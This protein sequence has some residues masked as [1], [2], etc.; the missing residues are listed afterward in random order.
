M[1]KPFEVVFI[2]IPA[3]WKNIIIAHFD[4]MMVHKVWESPVQELLKILW[5]GM[6]I[7][8][9]MPSSAEAGGFRVLKLKLSVQSSA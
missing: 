8:L 9:Q 6:D 5:Q 2:E 7:V 3:R 4:E 1:L